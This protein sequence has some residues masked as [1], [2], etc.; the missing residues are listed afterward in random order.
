MANDAMS[1]FTLI[2]ARGWHPAADC[3]AIVVRSVTPPGFLS[4][5]LG[6]RLGQ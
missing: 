3:V 4:L 6:Q 1:G 2:P 5:A